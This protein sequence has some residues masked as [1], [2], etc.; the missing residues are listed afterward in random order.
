MLFYLYL[1]CQLFGFLKK[2]TILKTQKIAAMK[3]MTKGEMRLLFIHTR[4][5]YIC[6]N[7][8]DEENMDEFKYKPLCDYC[9]MKLDMSGGKRSNELKVTPSCK[10]LFVQCSG[11][12]WLCRARQRLINMTHIH[13]ESE[14][15][16]TTKKIYNMILMH[17]L[18]NQQPKDAV[19]NI[20]YF[21]LELTKKMPH[22]MKTTQLSEFLIYSN[23]IPFQLTEGIFLVPPIGEE[24]TDAYIPPIKSKI[25]YENKY[26]ETVEKE[27]Y[28]CTPPA[29]KEDLTENCKDLAENPSPDQDFIEKILDQIK[30]YETLDETLHAIHKLSL[31]T[32]ACFHCVWLKHKVPGKIINCTGIPKLCSL[33][34]ELFN[35]WPPKFY[36]LDDKNSICVTQ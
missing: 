15:Q 3:N 31:A 20:E 4:V 29:W 28:G 27:E 22:L 13:W 25:K 36:L 8:L 6:L 34:Y 9:E 10:A 12:G 26:N 19:Y 14:G 16:M 23:Y 2:K 17:I 21:N 11:V 1:L 30:K 32:D 18:K 24:F 33:K 7:Y 35:A 5:Q